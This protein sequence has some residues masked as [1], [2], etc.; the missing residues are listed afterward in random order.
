MTNEELVTE[1]K[2]GST[3]LTLEL[4]NQNFKLIN[5]ICKHYSKSKEDTEDLLQQAYIALVKAVDMFD[6][7]KSQ[8]STYLV[9]ILRGD[10]SR[11]LRYNQLLRPPLHYTGYK[12]LLQT[13]Q[14]ITDQEI[15]N[16]L[17]IT[18]EELDRLK[19]YHSPHEY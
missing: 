17:K 11:Y 6:S 3:D 4:Y 10:I 1:I 9:H 19:A 5:K 7:T 2:A 16:T 18:V 12:R 15:I 13:N 8:F 14:D